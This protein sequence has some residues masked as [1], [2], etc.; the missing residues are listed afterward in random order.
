MLLAKTAFLDFTVEVVR[1]LQGQTSFQVQLRRWVMQC[2]FAWLMRHR[3]QVR[4]NEQHLEVS[5]AAM[6]IAL[7]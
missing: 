7:G 1:V 5:E 4:N 2:T 3:R 6:Y